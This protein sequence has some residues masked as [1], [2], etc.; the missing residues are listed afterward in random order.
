MKRTMRWL[1]VFLLALLAGCSSTPSVQPWNRP[2]KAEIA[3]PW[4]HVDNPETE[5]HRAENPY[6]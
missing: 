3:R 6:P 1:G 2:S 5:G 4:V